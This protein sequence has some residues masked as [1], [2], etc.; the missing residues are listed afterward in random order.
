MW[1]PWT[2]WLRVICQH[3]KQSE[4]IL[5]NHANSP[6]DDINTMSNFTLSKSMSWTARGPSAKKTLELQ[7]SNQCHRTRFGFSVESLPIVKTM[8]EFA[9]SSYSLFWAHRRQLINKDNYC[10]YN[11]LVVCS[12]SIP[13]L[14]DSLLISVC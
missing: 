1:F 11:R 7:T 5:I 4:H 8:T 13:K 6:S 14:F 2:H 10:F 3:R 12:Q 9:I